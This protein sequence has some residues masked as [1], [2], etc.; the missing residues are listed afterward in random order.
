MS[1]RLWFVHVLFRLQHCC[2]FITGASLSYPLS[3]CSLNLR[4]K[5]VVDISAEAGLSTVRQ[6]VF[7]PW[8][9]VMSL[10]Q[11][12]MFLWGGWELHLPVGI[13]ISIKKEVK[14]CVASAAIGSLLGSKASP[15]GQ[16]WKHTHSTSSK[17]TQRFYLHI[18]SHRQTDTQL[19]KKRPWIWGGQKRVKE[20]GAI[21]AVH[22]HELSK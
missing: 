20:G 6:F 8:H 11:K 10:L 5:G 17:W 15:S 19:K 12:R 16:S 13:R 9:I 4:C 21:N 18:Y 22:M 1:T 7:W 2:D 3:Q 14:D